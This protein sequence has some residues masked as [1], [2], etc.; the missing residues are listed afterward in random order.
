MM[1]KNVPI[2]KEEYTRYKQIKLKILLLFECIISKVEEKVEEK[3][4]IA[5]DDQHLI[6]FKILIKYTIS[7]AWNER[8]C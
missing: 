1:K 3:K 5:I 8:I 7:I 4:Y 6:Y 2:L